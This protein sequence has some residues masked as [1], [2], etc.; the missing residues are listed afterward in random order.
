MP[1]FGRFTI[2]NNAIIISFS[3]ASISA[4][5]F[6]LDLAHILELGGARTIIEVSAC[7]MHAI[8]TRYPTLE[9]LV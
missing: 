7:C 6:R 5:T 9:R 1:T 3:L 8:E 2:S 4:A